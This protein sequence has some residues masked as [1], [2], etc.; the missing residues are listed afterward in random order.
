[1][2]RQNYTDIYGLKQTTLTD[3][4]SWAINTAMLDAYSI[5][6]ITT[7][8]IATDQTLGT[9][10]N[11]SE[12]KR[13]TVMNNNTSTHIIKV[14]DEV[15]IPWSNKYF[16]WDW[17]SWTIDKWDVIW[18]EL[19]K[20]LSVSYHIPYM[21]SNATI[22]TL[23]V[24]EDRLYY[25]PYMTKQQI[26]INSLI[27]IYT[28]WVAASNIRL[29]IYS[30]GGWASG[31]AP[32]LLLADSG[33]MPST[34]VWWATLTYTLPTPLIIPVNTVIWFAYVC[35]STWVTNYGLAVANLW[36]IMWSGSVSS[37][38]TP[39]VYTRQTVTWDLPNPSSDWWAYTWSAWSVPVIFTSLTL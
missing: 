33:A 7:T 25:I 26:I 34:T 21:K 6:I 9:P 14:N 37:V 17:T 35:D 10:T 30:S 15:I 1:M 5:V 12:I 32:D 39:V 8:A 22:A 3:P 36:T 19:I 38:T 31:N 28:V 18:K 29:W 20:P 2:A 16:I 11:T 27:T 13:F 23:A 4:S 24:T